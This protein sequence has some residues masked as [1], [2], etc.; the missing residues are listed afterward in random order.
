[1]GRNGALN[2]EVMNLKREQEVKLVVLCEMIEMRKKVME[3][4][5]H[6]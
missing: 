5:N 1:M 4:K 3:E 6:D 2:E